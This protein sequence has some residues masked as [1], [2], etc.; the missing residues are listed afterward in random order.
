MT[1]TDPANLSVK[2]FPPLF[3]CSGVPSPPSPPCTGG[4]GGLFPL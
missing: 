1:K 4:L 3:R 2:V